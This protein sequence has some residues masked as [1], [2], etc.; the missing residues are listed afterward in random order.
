MHANQLGMYSCILENYNFIACMHAAT[1]SRQTSKLA[2]VSASIA[3]ANAQRLNPVVWRSIQSA[4]AYLL[5]C[6]PGENCRGFRGF[7]M[8]RKVLPTN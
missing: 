6:L 8:H 1:P 5:I 3:I 2:I 4:H 7:S